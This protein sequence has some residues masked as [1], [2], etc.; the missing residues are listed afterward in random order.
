M[1]SDNMQQE[2]DN[3]YRVAQTAAAAFSRFTL[4]Q[5]QTIVDAVAEAAEEKAEFYAEWA[6]RETGY[7]DIQAKIAKNLAT[8]VDL[9]KTYNIADYIQPKVDAEKK[10]FCIPKPAGVVLAPMPCTNP[11]MTVNFKVL[12][13]LIARNAVI[14]CP[15]PAAKGCSVHAAEFLAGVAEK[16]GAPK[17]SVQIIHEPNIELVNVLMKDPRLSLIHI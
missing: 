14:L 16:A 8:S 9:L 6:V 10:M 15:H 5:V 4:D 12:A 7:G 17:G 1:L 2:I 13:N 11:I 3:L